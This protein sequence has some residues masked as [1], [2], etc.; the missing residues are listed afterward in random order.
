MKNFLFF[1]LLLFSFDGYAKKTTEVLD[2]LKHVLEQTAQPSTTLYVEL[3]LAYLDTD[4]EKA[5]QYAELASQTAQKTAVSKELYW[6]KMA[7]GM[8][9]QH[10]GKTHACLTYL[11]EALQFGQKTKEKRLIIMGLDY[12]GKANFYAGNR[13][14]ALKYFIQ[15]VEM[16]LTEKQLFQYG[17]SLNEWLARIYAAQKNYKKAHFY[18]QKEKAHFEKIK[19]FNPALYSEIGNLHYAQKQYQLAYEWYEKAYKQEQKNFDKHKN[20]HAL[21][22]LVGNMGLAKMKMKAYTEAQ[23]LYEKARAYFQT[24]KSERDYVNVLSNLSQL[25]YE[26]NAL[27]QATEMAEDGY[28]KAKKMH[29]YELLVE[30]S[31]RLIQVYK[32]QGNKEQLYFYQGEKSQYQDTIA[33][34][35]QEKELLVLAFQEKN[36]LRRKEVG[37]LETRNNRLFYV[38]WATLLIIYVLGII[39]LLVARSNKLFRIVVQEKILLQQKI[40]Q[41]SQE[42]IRLQEDLFEEE[43]GKNELQEKYNALEKERMQDK[44]D[45]QARQLA[46]QAAIMVQK[47][48]WLV[49][50]EDT[51]KESFATLPAG[52]ANELRQHFRQTFAEIRQGINIENDWGS[53]KRHFEEVHPLFFDNIQR[54]FPKITHND[55]HTCAYLKINLS[56]KEIARILHIGEAS[57]RVNLT[58]LK[59]K[60]DLDRSQDLRTFLVNIA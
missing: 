33:H 31:S 28:Q 4:N 39:S 49:E 54:Q 18:L 11:E 26:T 57:L 59:A 14:T 7:V 30:L 47:N 32:Q 41:E 24:S 43:K 48:N 29:N 27:Q 16:E 20:Y 51:L 1:L 6:A 52:Q 55:L 53:Y 34:F 17:C 35:K 9:L 46:S 36:A 42:K 10:L 8:S 22:Y 23:K 21:G 38:T 44:I 12:L 2:S 15:I 19:L 56:I 5:Y 3:S 25:Y 60:F 45:F 40:L 13:E 37:E 50:I 58:R